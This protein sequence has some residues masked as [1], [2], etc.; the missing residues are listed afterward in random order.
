MFYGF[1][2]AGGFIFLIVL[3]VISSFRVLREYER[4]VVFLLGRFWR[5]KGPGLVLIV[6]AIQQ[7]VRVDLRTIVM[8]VPPQDVISHDNVSVKVNAVV[9]FRVVDPERAIIQVA[10]FL[11]A[12]SQLAQTTLRAILGKHELDEMLAEREK[13]NLDI[14]KVLD[15]QTDPWGIKIANVE[16]KHVDLNESMIRAIA[17]QAEAERE[18]RAK[19]IHAEGELQ[20]S[21]KLLE[22]ARMLAQQPE[23]IQLRY[24]QTLTQIAGDKSSTI[25]F[26]LPM[27]ML[28]ALKKA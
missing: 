1:F 22:A 2:S 13:L 15:I 23:A 25:V 20:A 16:I 27:D 21:E 14:Q 10:N 18:R 19:V 3:L 7:M 4:G 26:P 8:D 28:S 24:L 9:Y 6:P 5:V 17:R 11:E 12:T